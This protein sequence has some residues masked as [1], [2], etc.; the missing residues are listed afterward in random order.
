M[1]VFRR[2]D[3]WVSKFQH[4]GRQQW[5][6]GSPWPTK[7][8]AQEAERRYKDRLEARRTDE[9]CASFAERWLEEW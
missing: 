7:R 3:E 6:P 5:T 1:S 2:G 9:T 8:Q 4:R